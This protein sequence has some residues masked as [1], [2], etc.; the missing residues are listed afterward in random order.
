[1]ERVAVKRSAMNLDEE[2]GEEAMTVEQTEFMEQE[3]NDS[4]LAIGHV[5]YINILT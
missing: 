3:R 2:I 5:R 1:M 4:F